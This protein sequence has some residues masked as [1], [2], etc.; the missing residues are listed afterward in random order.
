MKNKFAIASIAAGVLLLSVHAA[1]AAC[2]WCD[3]TG[4]HVTPGPCPLGSAA[5]FTGTAAISCFG[6]GDSAG[7]A[8]LTVVGAVRG[9]VTS[10]SAFASYTVHEATG[11]ACVIS[12]T[13]D[14][15]LT[16]AING[17]FSWMRVGA[18]AV[19]S[20]AGDIDGQG[21]AAFAITSPIGNPCGGAVIA[22][23]GGLIGGG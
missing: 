12:G 14:G 10:G 23:V 3:E 13:A 1:N 16:G 20:T 11:A 6:C 8:S 19:I 7:T 2:V 21:I 9:S 4:C 17:S 5:Q 18:L 22:E 15:T